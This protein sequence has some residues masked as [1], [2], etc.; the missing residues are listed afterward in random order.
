MLVIKDLARIKRW[1]RYQWWRLRGYP[2]AGLFQI[3]PTP[4]PEFDRDKLSRPLYDNFTG[5]WVSWE[6]A[7]RKRICR[8]HH[9]YMP[10]ECPFCRSA[11]R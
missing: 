9:P 5:R 10:D 1:F 8:E 7:A 6:E 11:G 2:G 3:T 4:W